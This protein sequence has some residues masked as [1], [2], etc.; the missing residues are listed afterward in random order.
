MRTIGRKWPSSAPKGDFQCMCDYCGVQ[1]RRS[2][3]RRNRAGLLV[4]PDEGNG[5]DAV[6]LSEQNAAGAQ[7]YASRLGRQRRDP[8]NFDHDDGSS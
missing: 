3:L 5:R 2:Q 8:G 1:W 7:E 4:C 6:T